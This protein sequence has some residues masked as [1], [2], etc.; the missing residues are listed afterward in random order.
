MAD[1]EFLKIFAAETYGGG[2]GAFPDGRY[3]IEKARWANYDFRG[4]APGKDGTGVLT[5]AMELQP[6]SKNGEEEG[7]PKSQYWGFGNDE[8]AGHNK[9]KSLSYIGDK[10]PR[11]WD[12]S[13]VGVFMVHLLKAEGFDADQFE[14]END[15]SLLDGMV[16]DFSKVPSPRTPKAGAA[17]KKFPDQV[18]VIVSIVKAKKAA[19]KAKKD[20]AAADEKPAGKGKAASDDNDPADVIGEWLGTTLQPGAEALVTRI[21]FKKFLAGKFS[22]EDV[23]DGIF[24]Y[25]KDSAKLKAILKAVGWKLEGDVFAKA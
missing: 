8:F 4:K 20:E 12:K 21:A 17:E 5:L 16:A 6:L 22:D 2:E 18:A 15:V 10:S 9:G 3:R 14:S 11:I 19:G 23:R 25:Y 1:K 7:D 13:D 24:T